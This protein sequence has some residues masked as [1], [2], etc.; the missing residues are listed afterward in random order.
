[1]NYWP[2]MKLDDYIPLKII[3][4]R[5]K[6]AIMTAT[7]DGNPILDDDTQGD[8]EYRY[9]QLERLQQEVV[10]LEEMSGG[11]SIMGSG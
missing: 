7:G 5:M 11:I 1:M 2:D 3:E 4:T 10:D 6:L 8:L 9:K